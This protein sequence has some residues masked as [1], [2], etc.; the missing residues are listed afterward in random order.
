MMRYIDIDE[1]DNSI[2]MM[3]G[4]KDKYEIDSKDEIKEL[5]LEIII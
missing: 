2:R 4:K 5:I 3:I 1:Y